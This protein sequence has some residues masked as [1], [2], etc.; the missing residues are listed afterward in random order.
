MTEPVSGTSSDLSQN[1]DDPPVTADTSD[2][3]SESQ[4]EDEVEDPPDTDTVVPPPCDDIQPDQTSE[5]GTPPVPATDDVPRSDDE[6]ELQSDVTP[7][8]NDEFE[9]T[10]DD[11]T[12]TA[13]QTSG[14]SDTS[15]STDD[16]AD[17]AIPSAKP[18]TFP[19][20]PDLDY[21]IPLPHKTR[22]GRTTKPNPKYL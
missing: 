1:C 18:D 12:G 13:P 9:Q 2:V 14:S 10:E 20:V 5:A 19:T 4:T 3:T 7:D 16:L 8:P 15:P 22:S 17:T 11:H 21:E 6:P